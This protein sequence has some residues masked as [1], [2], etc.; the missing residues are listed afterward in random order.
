MDL[1]ALRSQPAGSRSHI[2][3]DT[4]DKARAQGVFSRSIQDKSC[5]TTLINLLGS[6]GFGNDGA[7][8]KAS[9]K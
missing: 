2:Q 6:T 9:G 3:R 1:I 8:R 4:F 5:L 7:S